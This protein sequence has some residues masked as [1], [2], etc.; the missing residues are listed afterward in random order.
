MYMEFGKP[1]QMH[2]APQCHFL[3]FITI[4]MTC[5]WS[6]EIP[7]Q[8][9]AAPWCLFLNTFWVWVIRSKL[10]PNKVKLSLRK[11]FAKIAKSRCIWKTNNTNPMDLSKIP[12]LSR[13][14]ENQGNQ[15]TLA[16]PKSNKPLYV[17]HKDLSMSTF[18]ALHL[19]KL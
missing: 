7:G 4:L 9:Y 5:T 1:R 18:I 15:E 11:I 8:I 2:A 16:P 19:R 17:F 14:L 10:P 12:I 6:L 3:T 13:R